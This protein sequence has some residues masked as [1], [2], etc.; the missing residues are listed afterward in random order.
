MESHQETDVYVEIPSKKDSFFKRE[1]VADVRAK[2][3]DTLK[4]LK[5]I[6]AFQYTSPDCGRQS[7][8]SVSALQEAH[9]KRAPVWKR[10][11]FR[12]QEVI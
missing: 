7:L 4:D 9:Q 11:D 3:L 6:T 8:L 10:P 12:L 5:K 1:E 2:W